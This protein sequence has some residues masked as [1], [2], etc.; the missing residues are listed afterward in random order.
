MKRQKMQLMV[1]GVLLLVLLIVFFA[2]RSY[3]KEKQETTE[4]DSYTVLSLQ[5]ADVVKFAFD[6]ENEEVSLRKEAGEWV[7]EKDTA[8]ELAQDEISSLLGYVLD[9]QAQVQIQNVTDFE[10]YGFNDPLA[11]VRITL[12]D[13]TVYEIVFGH[14]NEVT[15]QYY[16]KLEDSDTVYV[17]S[18]N[19]GYHFTIS[20][21]DLKKV[22]TEDTE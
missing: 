17:L 14:Y 8:M 22:E 16:M 6:G 18:D 7:A 20:L 11:T 5:E 10:Q 4:E 2:L 3:N 21:E 1:L 12:Q 15:A 19:L 13:D 9:I